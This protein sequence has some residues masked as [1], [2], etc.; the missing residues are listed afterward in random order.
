MSSIEDIGI[1]QNTDTDTD[2]AL[3]V[4]NSDVNEEIAV[5]KQRLDSPEPIKDDRAESENVEIRI[6]KHYLVRKQRR[7]KFNALRNLDY[8]VAHLAYNDQVCE[9]ANFQL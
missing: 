7:C 4:E 8:C 2:R 6:C 5:K 3:S 1:Q 9:N